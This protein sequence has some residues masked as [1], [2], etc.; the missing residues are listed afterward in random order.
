MKI[1]PPN[2]GAP[3][4]TPVTFGARAHADDNR[5]AQLSR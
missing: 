5:S 1:M 3:N 2:P 4:V